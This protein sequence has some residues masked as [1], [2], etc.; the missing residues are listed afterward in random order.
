[1]QQYASAFHFV[2]A[3]V[4]LRPEQGQIYMLLAVALAHLDDPENAEQAYTA[5]LAVQPQ[6][7]AVPLNFAVFLHAVGRPGAAQDQLTE[8]ERRVAAGRAAGNPPSAEASHSQ[9][10]PG[11]C[12]AGPLWRQ[13]LRSLSSALIA[14]G[15]TRVVVFFFCGCVHL[16]S[17]E[18]GNA[19]LLAVRRWLLETMRTFGLNCLIYIFVDLEGLWYHPRAYIGMWS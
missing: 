12:P 14:F 16:S 4:N 2:S 9:M 7:P 5:A 3:A 19:V 6:D 1:M 10:L 15:S 18:L 13:A 17:L 11:W 8:Y